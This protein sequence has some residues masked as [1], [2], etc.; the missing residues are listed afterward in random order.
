MRGGIR[1]KKE[2]IDIIERRFK[3]DI[4]KIES[5]IYRNKSEI[6]RLAEKQKELKNIRK[7]LY[8]I[9]RQIKG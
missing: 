1:V 4:W 5:E 9:L 8:E 2:T 7:G 6:K 3:E